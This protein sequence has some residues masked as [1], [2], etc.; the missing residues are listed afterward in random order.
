ME[1]RK[2]R[3]NSNVQFGEG[4]AGTFSDG[5]LTTRVKDLRGRKVLEALVEAGAPEDILYMA[6]PHVGTDLLRGVVKNI[7]KKYFAW[8]RSSIQ[9]TSDRFYRRK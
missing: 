4:G 7:V 3:S 1:R 5:K 8:W 9:Y 2:V 6:H